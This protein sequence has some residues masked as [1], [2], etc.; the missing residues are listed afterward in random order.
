M[1]ALTSAERYKRAGVGRVYLIAE[2]YAIHEH[3]PLKAMLVA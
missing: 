3:A 1:A 2:K